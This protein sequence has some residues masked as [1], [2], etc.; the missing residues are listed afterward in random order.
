MRPTKNLKMSGESVIV[1]NRV[2]FRGPSGMHMKSCEGY[3]LK[4]TSLLDILGSYLSQGYNSVKL[5]MQSLSVFGSMADSGVDS[6]NAG[7][8]ASPLKLFMI[9]F[10]VISIVVGVVLAAIVKWEL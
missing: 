6:L 9:N 2:T 3:N 1:S 10:A 7:S 8:M 5:T 4:E